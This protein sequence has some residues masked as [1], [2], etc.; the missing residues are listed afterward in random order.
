MTEIFEDEEKVAVVEDEIL[1]LETDEDSWETVKANQGADARRRLEDM[2][3]EKK[4]KAD[5]DDY[6]ELDDL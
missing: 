2:L 1:E 5:L 4:L 3:D 6:F